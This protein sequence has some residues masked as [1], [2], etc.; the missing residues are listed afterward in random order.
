MCRKVP[1]IP[2]YCV[3]NVVYLENKA[4]SEIS[5]CDSCSQISLLPRF[6]GKRVIGLA[7]ITIRFLCYQMNADACTAYKRAAL[8]RPHVFLGYCLHAGWSYETCCI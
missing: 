8:R 1:K 2:E 5:S 3:V 7:V 4:K 6:A